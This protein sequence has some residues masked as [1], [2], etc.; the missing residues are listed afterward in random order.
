MKSKPSR[1][2]VTP[3]EPAGIGPD[4]TVQMAQYSFPFEIVAIADAQLLEERAH[5]LGLPLRIEEFHNETSP[6][7]HQAGTLKVLHSP[8]ANKPH[9]GHLDTGNVAY[10]LNTL[11]RAIMGCL[12]GEFSALVTG[13]VHKG[14][15]N[16]AGITFTGHTEF[17]AELSNTPQAVMML[18]T[19]GLRVALVTTHIPL[20]EISSR[21]TP[22]LLENTLKITHRE[23]QCYFAI[24][25]PNMIVCGLNPHAGENGHLGDEEKEIM[26][27]V[28]EN[29]RSQGLIIEGPLPAD[30]AFIPKYL[31]WADVF[32]AMYH[33]Q[34]LPVLK[35]M[36]FGDA[37]NITLGLPFIRTSV[38]HGTALELAGSGKSDVTSLI[39]AINTANEM[40]GNR[41]TF[42]QQPMK[43]RLHQ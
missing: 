27:P 37:I 9:C 33:D 36:G 26:I 41:Q 32:I 12:N 30:T 40:M 43:T 31:D 19:K 8:C 38:D 4:I 20:R 16:D 1:I 21:I 5:L 7:P 10:V 2:A 39:S 24:A 28:L 13:P 3:G 23:L 14:N 42:M 6:A 17:L 18:A 29:L 34:G 25:Q 11:R 35:H 15:I 22:T